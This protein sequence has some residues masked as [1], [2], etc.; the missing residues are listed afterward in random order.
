MVDSVG[1]IGTGIDALMKEYHTVAHNI[2]NVNTTGYKRRVNSFSRELMDQISGG[3][4]ESVSA[5]EI[6]ANSSIDFSTG[7]LFVTGRSLDVAILGRG[8]FVVETP[9]GPLYTRNGIFQ[10]NTQGQLVDLENRIVAG[11]GGPL[12]IPPTVSELEVNIAGDGNVR[13]GEALLG[14]LRVV[15]FGER[16]NELEPAGKSC[17]KADPDLLGGGAENMSLKQGYRENSNVKLVEELVDL[18][19]VSRLYEI[20]MS[21][22]RKERE[23]SQAM[24]SV[25]NS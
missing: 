22:L 14:K 23:N 9:D 11:E 5:A 10:I 18:I 12:V 2:A 3:G 1:Q 16:E 8:F 4:E 15:D 24:L 17:F 7:S 20:N 21:L 6:K 25:A 19:G 13:A